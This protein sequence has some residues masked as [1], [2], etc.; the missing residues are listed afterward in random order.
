MTIHNTEIRICLSK[1]NLE[2]STIGYFKLLNVLPVAKL[3]KKNSY[4]IYN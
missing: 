1:K 3:Y 4:F 2:G